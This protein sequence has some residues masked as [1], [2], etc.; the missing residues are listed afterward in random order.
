MFIFG[1]NLKTWT[2]L[3]PR[4][5]LNISIFLLKLSHKLFTCN[6]CSLLSIA[7]V[8][9]VMLQGLSGGKKCGNGV[10]NETTTLQKMYQGNE[11]HKWSHSWNQALYQA[12]GCAS[13]FL[14]LYSNPHQDYFYTYFHKNRRPYQALW[15][16]KN[17]KICQCYN[18][19]TWFYGCRADLISIGIS[20]VSSDIFVPLCPQ[21]AWVRSQ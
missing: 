2:L 16:W 8:V 20:C 21:Q 1:A 12:W 18:Y 3:R 15:I 6:L 14:S 17:V 19:Q 10:T 7:D 9:M 5:K 13:Y 11:T 4:P